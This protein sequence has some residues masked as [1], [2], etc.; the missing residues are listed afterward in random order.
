MAHVQLAASRSPMGHG[1]MDTPTWF[2]MLVAPT[3]RPTAPRPP[4]QQQ[5]TSSLIT[6]SLPCAEGRVLLHDVSLHALN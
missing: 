3:P 2:R 6:T 1:E 5:D 4:P